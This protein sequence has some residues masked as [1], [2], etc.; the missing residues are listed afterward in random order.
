MIWIILPV[1]CSY[2]VFTD[3]MTPYPDR[4]FGA[5]SVAALKRL[6]SNGGTWSVRDAGTS[7][8]VGLAEGAIKLVADN[9]IEDYTKALCRLALKGEITVREYGSFSDIK[10][11]NISI[12]Y[13]GPVNGRR[14]K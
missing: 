8:R 10:A 7:S 2:G 1:Y 14:V 12:E 5:A 6:I 13:I 3:E 4:D 9:N 11:D